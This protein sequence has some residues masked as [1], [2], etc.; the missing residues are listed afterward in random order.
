VSLHRKVM[1][2]DNEGT[3]KYNHAT[4]PYDR[5]ADKFSATLKNFA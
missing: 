4:S 5:A 2:R 1:A 3:I